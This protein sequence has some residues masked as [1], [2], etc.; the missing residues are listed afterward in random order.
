MR[1][2]DLNRLIDPASDVTTGLDQRRRL[3]PGVRDKR[4]PWLPHPSTSSQDLGKPLLND[5]TL[6]R[7]RRSKVDVG[8][9]VRQRPDPCAGFFPPPE[10]SRMRGFRTPPSPKQ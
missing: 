7:D 9:T 2:G 4:R 8:S 3:D 10:A 1:P 6:V 5:P